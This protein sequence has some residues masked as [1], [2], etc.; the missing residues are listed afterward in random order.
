MN[1]RETNVKMNVDDRDTNNTTKG[2][3][4]LSL[5]CL[6]TEQ[7][8]RLDIDLEEA[9]GYSLHI[10]SGEPVRHVHTKDI[11]PARGFFAGIERQS[12]LI[13]PNTHYCVTL[14]D[15]LFFIMVDTQEGGCH[16]KLMSHGAGIEDLTYR[17]KSIEIPPEE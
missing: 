17:G 14:G 3:L 6:E 11:E 10:E 12:Y 9:V 1:K 4:W 7:E 2:T 15:T 13:H 16:V 5:E 8:P